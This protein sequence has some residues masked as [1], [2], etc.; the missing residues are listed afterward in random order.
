MGLEMYMRQV[1]IWRN[2]QKKITL[3]EVKYRNSICYF[4]KEVFLNCKITFYD[5]IGD[6]PT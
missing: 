2:K 1:Q 6:V 5:G 3:T 4:N